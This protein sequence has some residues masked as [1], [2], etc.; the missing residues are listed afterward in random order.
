MKKTFYLLALLMLWGS[1]AN[2]QEKSYQGGEWFKF[3]IHYGWFNASYAT[4]EVNE[5]NYNSNQ[6]YHVIGKGKST[7]LMHVFF[8][9][10]DTYETYIDKSSNL[11]LK[12]VRNI[13]EGGYEKNRLIYFD[14]KL[15]KAKVKDLKKDTENTF[16]TKANV[17]DMLSVFYFLRNKIDVNH[18]KEGDEL[19]VDLFFDDE[20]HK[21]KTVFLGREVL[22]TKFGKIN[23]LKFRPYVQADRIF[24][25][26][27][28]L[29]FWVSDDHNKI[30]LKIKAN[31]AVGSLEADLEEFK[32]LRH[33][34]KVIVD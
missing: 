27:E 23:S 15:K 7:G 4:L 8:G 17:Q 16:E 28:S 6:V 29:T 10:D 3:R 34:F 19:F 22:K 24:K 18:L 1:L 20:I 13:N 5:E 30:P 9:V 2:A 14:Q 21:F 32:G 12:F 31:L 33:S 11:P 26:E 25:E